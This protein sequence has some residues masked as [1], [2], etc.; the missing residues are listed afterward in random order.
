MTTTYPAGLGVDLCVF[1]C[2]MYAVIGRYALSTLLANAG[3]VI[4]TNWQTRFRTPEELNESVIFT[5]YILHVPSKDYRDSKPDS[6]GFESRRDFPPSHITNHSQ[7][8]ASHVTT[9]LR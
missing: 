3:K 5:D 2:Y 7:S 6:T 4:A 1:K 8:F 9:R